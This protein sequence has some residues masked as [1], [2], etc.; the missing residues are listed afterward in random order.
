MGPGHRPLGKI[1]WNDKCKEHF[2]LPADVEVD[3]GLFYSIL[4]QEDS[5]RTRT[6]VERAVY[7]GAPYDIEY[8]TVAPDGRVRA[9][10][11]AYHDANGIPTRFDGVTL[12][13]SE[14]KKTEQ[15]REEKLRAERMA[16]EEAE[17]VSRMK[18]EFLATLSHELRTPL[19]AIVGWSQMLSQR[20]VLND[21]IRE[22]LEVIQRNAKAQTKIIEDL[23]DMS[24]IISGK[25][26]LDVQRLSLADVV[27]TAVQSVRP[28]AEVK[29]IRLVTVLDP[30]AGP[31]L[32]I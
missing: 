27:S 1:I 32:A 25:V 17:R 22:G 13:I 24:R 19:N 18:D 31:S 9:K 16:R 11:R 26:R 15:L 14:L 5:E 3:F 30:Y 2:W 28:S 29:G 21:A 10:G 20:P 12:D 6:A 7:H 23:L 4:H 8:R